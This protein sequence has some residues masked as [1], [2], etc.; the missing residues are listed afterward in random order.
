MRSQKQKTLPLLK[1]QNYGNV[2]RYRIL[3]YFGNRL[4]LHSSQ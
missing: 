3:I 4:S 1:L 2:R